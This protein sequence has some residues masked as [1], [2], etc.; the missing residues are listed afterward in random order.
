MQKSA[1]V[2]AG[3][4]AHCNRYWPLIVDQLVRPITHP[5]Y[6]E[7]IYFSDAAGAGLA[8][9]RTGLLPSAA[10]LLQHLDCDTPRAE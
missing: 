2:A 5:I 10:T 3:Y 7:S 6:S 1:T 4:I 9:E 8:L